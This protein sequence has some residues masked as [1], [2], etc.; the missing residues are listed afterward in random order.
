MLAGTVP[1]LGISRSTPR[2]ISRQIPTRGQIQDPSQAAWCGI[3]LQN[4]NGEP[5]EPSH[6]NTILH[7]EVCSLWE[8][9]LVPVIFSYPGPVVENL[10]LPGPGPGEVRVPCNLLPHRLPFSAMGWLSLFSCRVL[11]SISALVLNQR[12]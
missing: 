12:L 2:K 9:H 4:Q 1:I 3:Q 6:L 11:V 7:V 8:R 10:E 5:S